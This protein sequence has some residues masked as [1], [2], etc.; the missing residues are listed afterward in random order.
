MRPGA[1][2]F[3]VLRRAVSGVNK[4]L[5]PSRVGSLARRSRLGRGTDLK[6]HVGLV[7]VLLILSVMYAHR[8]CQHSEIGENR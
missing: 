3:A 8:Q 1:A 6:M 5:P 4:S 7:Q 2:L